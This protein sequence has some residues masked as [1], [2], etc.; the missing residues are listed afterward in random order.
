MKL[1]YLLFGLSLLPL[2]PLLKRDGRR[3]LAAVPRLPE[4]TGTSGDVEGPGPK[5]NMLCIGESTM[6]GVGVATHQEGVAFHLARTLVRGWGRGVH[7]QVHARSGY[8][9]KLLTQEVLPQIPDKEWDL[10]VIA[11]GANEVFKTNTPAGVKR[12]I[13]ALIADLRERFGH[14]VPIAFMNMPPIREFPALTPLLRFALGKMVEYVG[15]ELAAIVATEPNVYYNAEKMR[16]ADW[17][18][19]L[20]VAPDPAAFFSDGIHPSAMTY[21]VWGEDFGR[22]LLRELPAK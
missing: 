17:A 12:D 2:F 8:T 19:R 10:I 16:L 4:A 18:T 11:I 13:K 3:V 5:L 9:I 1:K 14:D 20:G 15:E 6:A 21:R 22:F 7:W